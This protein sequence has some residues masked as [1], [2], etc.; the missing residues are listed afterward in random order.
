MNRRSFLGMTIGGSVISTAV[1]GSS[2]AAAS[3]GDIL[4]E[5][6]TGGHIQSAPT[7]VE[8]TIYVGSDDGALY[9]VDAETGNE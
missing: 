3:S 8:G 4:W 7:I 9:A 5:F 1:V 2:V 6:E